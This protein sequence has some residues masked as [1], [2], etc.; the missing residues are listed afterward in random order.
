[1]RPFLLPEIDL[2]FKWAKI[3]HKT[4][5]RNQLPINGLTNSIYTLI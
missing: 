1:M 5:Q 4:D 2:W 3:D